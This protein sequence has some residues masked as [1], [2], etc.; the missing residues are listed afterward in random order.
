MRWLRDMWTKDGPGIPKDA[1]KKHGLALFA[2]IIRREWWEMVKLNLLFI[3][4]SLPIVTIPAALAAMASVSVA[5]VEDRNIYL[6]RDFCTAFRKHLWQ[7]TMA[8]F[9]TSSALALGVYATV[10]YASLAMGKVVFAVPLAIS[11]AATVF[12]CV[13]ACHDLVLMVMRDLPLLQRVRLAALATLARPLPAIGAIGF[14]AALWL[15]H[16]L[17]YPISVFMPAT[18]N[19]SLGMF[20]VTFGVHRAA[21]ES[22]SKVTGM[23]ASQETRVGSA[24]QNI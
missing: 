4:A 7:A 3:L 2:E 15:V 24:T 10:T 17:L 1:A 19:F 20:A 23:Q 8:G 18:L 14:C 11:L 16:V 12:I 5:L 6:G 22:L 13:F 21:V 9:T